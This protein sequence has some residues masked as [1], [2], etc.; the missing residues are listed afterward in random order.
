MTLQAKPDDY[1]AS[2]NLQRLATAVLALSP[3]AAI[4][5]WMDL[6]SQLH[7]RPFKK[8]GGAARRST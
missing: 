6:M 2:M 3:G 4:C 8:A 5:C 7:G 1:I